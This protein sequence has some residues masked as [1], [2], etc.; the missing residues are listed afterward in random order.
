M[1]KGDPQVNIKN[2][3]A[4]FNFHLEQVFTAGIKL[5]GTEIKSLRDSQA[6][7]TDSYCIFRKGELWVKSMYIAEYTQGTYNN[8]EPRRMRK[9]LLNK[10]EL[11]KLNASVREKGF[12]IVPVR[13]FIS[14]RGYAKLEIA[15]A[16]GKKS[17]DKRQSIKQKDT[18]RELDR[19]LKGNY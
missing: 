16:K 12:S 6:S 2:R 9:L 5:T 18:K 13:L 8:H 19:A 10:R 14:E 7:L 15:L 3:K 11:K 4:A 1:K 17:F